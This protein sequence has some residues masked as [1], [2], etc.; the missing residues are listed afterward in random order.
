MRKSILNIY[1]K[2]NIKNCGILDKYLNLNNVCS[3]VNIFNIK[4][5]LLQMFPKDK[6]I[7]RGLDYIH[8]FY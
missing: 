1:I 3:M 2:A 4:Y 7:I 5:F 8:D 6:Y